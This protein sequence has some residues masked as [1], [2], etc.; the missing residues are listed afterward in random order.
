MKH[1]IQPLQPNASV[2]ALLEA[3]RLP[4]S[5][6]QDGSEVVLFGCVSGAQTLGVVGLELYG[7]VALLRSLAVAD[8]TRGNGLGEALV[9][10]AERHAAAQGVRAV[11]LLTTTA[12]AFFERRGYRPLARDQAPAAIA[13]TAQFS[14]LCPASSAFMVKSPPG[15]ADAQPETL[16]N[17]GVRRGDIYWLAPDGPH[18]SVPSIRHPHVVVQDDLFN[19]SRVATI[20]VCGITS[21]LTRASE[22]GT[23]LLDAGEGGL[24]RRSVVLASQICSV[25]RAQFGDCVGTLSQRRVEQILSSLRFLQRAFIAG[26]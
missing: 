7:P 3:N 11:Y 8:A 21:N 5:D 6:L 9:A 12:S 20:V 17:R 14:G 25:D 18:G 19:A 16:P 13:G 23:V 4:V 2:Q 15:A 10:H 1:S 22:P 26:R 24:A